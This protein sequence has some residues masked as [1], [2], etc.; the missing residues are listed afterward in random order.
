MLGFCIYSGSSHSF[1]AGHML[2][3]VVLEWIMALQL[4]RE[5]DR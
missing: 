5:T 4:Q 1:T 3:R 2:S